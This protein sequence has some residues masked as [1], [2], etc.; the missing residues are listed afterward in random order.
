MSNESVLRAK[1]FQGAKVKIDVAH[2]VVSGHGLGGTA[3]I[4][5]GAEDGRVRAMTVQD[6]WMIEWR[7]VRKPLQILLSH[8]HAHDTASFNNKK[9][10]N[11]GK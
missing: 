2:L 5:V 4:E 7:E 6:P 10:E 1:L 11:Q 9:P 8:Q 3:A